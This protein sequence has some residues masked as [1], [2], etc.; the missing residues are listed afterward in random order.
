[1]KK[2]TLYILA[3][4]F[5]SVLTANAQTMLIDFGFKQINVNGSLTDARMPS[6]WNN[7]THYNL[8]GGRVADGNDSII[9]LIDNTA[10]STGIVFTITDPFDANNAAG[11]DPNTPTTG[12]AF[13]A[14]FTGMAAVDNLY[15]YYSATNNP[16]HG[17]AVM[18]LSNLDPA[19]VYDFTFYSARMVTDNR[20]GKLTATGLNTASDT[21][22]SASNTSRVKTLAAI[23]PDANNK[24][25]LKFEF[26]PSN[27]SSYAYLSALKITGKS[28]STK[29]ENTEVYTLSARVQNDNL[30]VGDYTGLVKVYAVNG[31]LVANGQAIFGYMPLKL[32]KG[33][34]V[35]ETTQGKCKLMVH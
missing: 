8:S 30:I 4:L 26:S 27:N 25:E 20:A 28:T 21:L 33:V 29:V 19:K 15:I 11:V 16:P 22:N 35:V 31:K 23:V 17:I 13:N 1:M 2:F 7:I 5:F 18:E 10:T 12:D 24:I 14:G 9:T 32:Q 3:T 6:P 34:Y